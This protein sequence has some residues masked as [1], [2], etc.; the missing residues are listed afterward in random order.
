MHHDKN[1]KAATRLEIG[2]PVIMN[3]VDGPDA[4]R[5]AI[6]CAHDPATGAWEAR[7]LNRAT[8]TKTC[9]N[10]LSFDRPTPLEDF[11]VEIRALSHDV[12]EVERIGDS[13]ATY[14]DGVSRRWSGQEKS[15]HAGRAKAMLL[16]RAWLKLRQER[17]F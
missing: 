4:R 6:L 9:R 8:N 10:S 3:D 12:Y 2:M 11:G 15:V 5:I 14:N 7:Y 16:L 1:L 17:G 13:V